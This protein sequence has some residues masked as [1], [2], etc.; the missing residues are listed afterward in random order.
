VRTDR[1]NQVINTWL[2]GGYRL[3]HVHLCKRTGTAFVVPVL[4]QQPVAFA[5]RRPLL[6]ILVPVLG[7][8]ML[9]AVLAVALVGPVIGIGGHFLALPLRFPGPLAYRVGAETL[10]LDPGI[11]Q[12]MTATMSTSMGAVHGSLL[13]EAINLAKLLQ[14]E[15]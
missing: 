1:W 5:V 14:Q 15:E 2:N 8:L 3:Y 9:P 12:K 6:T 4:L 11:W 7:M 13:S 10:G